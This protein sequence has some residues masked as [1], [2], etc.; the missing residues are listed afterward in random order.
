MKRALMFALAATTAFGLNPVAMIAH[1]S[2][3]AEYD[4][5]KPVTLTGSVTRV[6]WINPHARFHMDVKDDKGGAN[7]EIELGS[8]AGLL[9]A[10]WTRNSLKIGDEVV[11][12][13]YLAKDGANLA[14]STT[15]TLNGKRLFAGSSSETSNPSPTSPTNP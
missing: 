1:H 13:G 12:N 9:R 15:V 2:F 6:E 5:A 3:A 8:P 11:V 14:N 4:R 7:W 10:G